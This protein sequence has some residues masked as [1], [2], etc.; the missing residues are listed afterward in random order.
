MNDEP[1]SLVVLT[2]V[3]YINFLE[4]WRICVILPKLAWYSWWNM[5]VQIVPE[6]SFVSKLPRSGWVLPFYMLLLKMSPQV[7]PQKEFDPPALFLI[8]NTFVDSS[9]RRSRGDAKRIQKTCAGEERKDFNH[10]RHLGGT[11]RRHGA[12]TWDWWW[13][14][15]MHACLYV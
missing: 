1:T 12:F 2:L 13:R 11:T 10:V 4:R 3:N 9:F 7:T 8:P 6:S 15:D 5:A 14:C